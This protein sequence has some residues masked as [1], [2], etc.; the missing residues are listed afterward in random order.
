M[1]TVTQ[2]KDL[3]QRVLGPRADELARETQFV[4]RKRNL[5]G[6]DFVQGL[7]FGYL[8][9]ANATS[10]EIMQIMQRREVDISA[11]GLSQ[12]F[13]QSAAEFLQRMMQEVIKEQIQAEQ[14]APAE[15]L[16]RFDAVIVEDS[17]TIK[18]PD[19]L[20]DIWAGCGGGQG[21][22]K[23]GLKLHVRWDLKQG[24]LQG[25]ILTPSRHG[26][27]TSP[28]RQEGIA[29][30]VLNI[31]DEAY[32]S[33]EWLKEQEGFF[34]TRPR[35]TVHFLDRQSGEQ[36]DLD[37][38][39]PKVSNGTWQGEVFV[40]KEARLPARLILIRVPEEVIKQRQE[41]IREEAKRRG[42]AVNQE[43]LKRAQWTILITN[44]PAQMLTI[45]QVVVLQRARW[46]IERLFRLWKEGGKIDE[47]RGTTP[48]R[49]L[50]EI[51][52]K[53]IALL[54]QHWFLVI[55]TWHDPYRSLVKAAKLVRQYAPEL[56]SAL[57]GE[58]CWQRVT[59]R[60]LRA[61]QA[62]RLH[63]RLKY[64]CHAQLLLDGL[65]WDLTEA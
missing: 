1:S 43:S 13:T 36:L 10:E 65:D 50:C 54:I 22:S 19:K 26:D 38:I 3:L 39:G 4:R 53:V 14:P 5:D 24:G 49:I 17:T 52:A 37:E 9:Q 23:A 35:S 16:G 47:W 30:G 56:L 34:L 15:L 57:V 2:V 11:P 41:R 6:S 27:Q 29:A 64:P 62:C 21:Q 42:R 61:M 46:Q 12:R 31:T 58:T 55:G 44:V 28:L 7:V 33:L 20:K 18:L 45:A 8:H 25:P 59:S 60:L 51:Y 32:S 48:W 63:R 40:G